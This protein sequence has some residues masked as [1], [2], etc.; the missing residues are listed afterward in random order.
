MKHKE[1]NPGSVYVPKDVNKIHTEY[2]CELGILERL[3]TTMFT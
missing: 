1:F 3:N 2:L